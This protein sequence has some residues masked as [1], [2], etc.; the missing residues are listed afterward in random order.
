MDKLNISHAGISPQISYTPV[1]SHNNDFNILQTLGFSIFNWPLLLSLVRLLECI[2]PPKNFSLRLRVR[3]TGGSSRCPGSY[4]D[5]EGSC[6]GPDVGWM[7]KVWGSHWRPIWSHLA[8]YV[9]YFDGVYVAFLLGWGSCSQLIW[10]SIV[11]FSDLGL[12]ASSASTGSDFGPSEFSTS[13]VSSSASKL[14]N[15][16]D[17]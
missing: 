9:N 5:L 4:G 15:I 11:F 10:G 17:P 8:R 2:L 16:P 13:V 3:K 14:E 7:K 1:S 6:Q 12:S